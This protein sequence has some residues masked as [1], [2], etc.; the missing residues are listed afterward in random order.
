MLVAKKIQQDLIL[1]CVV[2]LYARKQMRGAEERRVMRALLRCLLETVQSGGRI[3]RKSL[4]TLR[5]TAARGPDRAI[6]VTLRRT[7][8]LDGQTAVLSDGV[9]LTALQRRVG[10]PRVAKHSVSKV[11]LRQRSTYDGSTVSSSSR[12]PPPK[13]APSLSSWPKTAYTHGCNT[14]RV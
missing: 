12:P 14:G 1:T 7:A 10:R 8:F 9:M 2:L 4:R 11:V 3:V 13:H 6:E 5:V